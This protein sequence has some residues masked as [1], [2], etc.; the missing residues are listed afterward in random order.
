MI[1]TRQPVRQQA[2]EPP[3]DAERWLAVVPDIRIPG[4]VTRSRSSSQ[5]GAPTTRTRGSDVV[6]WTGPK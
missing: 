2:G 1:M 3:V 6:V 4:D 5:T